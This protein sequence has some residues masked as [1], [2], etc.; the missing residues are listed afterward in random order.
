MTVPE[1]F[2]CIGES[3]SCSTEMLVSNDKRIFTFQ[4]HPEYL[5]EYIRVM[6]KRWLS[7]DKNTSVVHQD[8]YAA[9][10]EHH[11]TVEVMCRAIRKFMD[12]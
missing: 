4:F 3:D 8:K 6:E 12:Y 5:V 10:S 9:D 1:G 2:S 11:A 7:L